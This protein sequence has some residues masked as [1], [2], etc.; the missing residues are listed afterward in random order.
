MPASFDPCRAASLLAHRRRQDPPAGFLPLR[1]AESVV[2]A[3]WTARHRSFALVAGS[4][5]A[6][7][8]PPSTEPPS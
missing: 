6:G 4:T 5:A 7:A 2:A 1:Q 8:P 3:P